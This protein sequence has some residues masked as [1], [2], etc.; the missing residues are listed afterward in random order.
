MFILTSGSI[1][2]F[3]DLDMSGSFRI[4]QKL[5]RIP[6]FLQVSPVLQGFLSIFPQFLYPFAAAPMTRDLAKLYE[7]LET[8]RN[9]SRLLMAKLEEMEDG[10]FVAG[11]RGA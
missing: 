6:P 9:P 11:R 1:I 4:F 2:F 5:L 10:Q 7:I 3:T 8:A